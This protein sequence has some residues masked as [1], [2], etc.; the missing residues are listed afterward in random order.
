MVAAG[1]GHGGM[2]VTVTVPPEPRLLLLRSDAP[3]QLY[4]ES[5]LAD[6]GLPLSVVVE[7]GARQRVRLRRQR[8][9]R[10]W[11]WR[12]YQDVRHRWSGRSRF[13]RAYFAGPVP[14]L[15]RH[16]VDWI[17]SAAARRLVADAR[18]EVVI[19]C[20]TSL[21]APGIL[22]GVPVAVNVHGGHLPAYK[23]NHGVFFAFA[24]G[25]FDYIGASLHLV[26]PE[27]DAGPLLAV[28][29]PEMRPDDHD[30]H[31]YCRAVRDV[32]DLLCVEL[33]RLSRG[34]MMRASAQP[35]GGSTFR[36]RDRTPWIEV[37][38]WWR[39][40]TGRLRAP[41]RTASVEVFT[42]R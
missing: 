36:H 32:V 19:V 33:I 25:D 41:A 38:T 35:D 28:V 40:R 11:F 1:G 30:G 13:A 37:R 2:T 22:A 7:S 20:G 31:L 23:G 9:W 3:Q 10:S 14:D 4:L 42:E 39:R 6:T 17:S 24:K 12:V 29:R 27:L 26:T 15:Q 21:I 34:G 8:R 16:H 18:P 5:R